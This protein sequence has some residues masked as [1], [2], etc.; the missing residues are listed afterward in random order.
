MEAAHDLLQETRGAFWATVAVVVGL[1]AYP[2]S[3]GLATVAGQNGGMSGLIDKLL[4]IALTPLGLEVFGLTIL[5]GSVVLATFT[6]MQCLGLAPV[7]QAERNP[8]TWLLGLLASI[9]LGIVGLC[10]SVLFWPRP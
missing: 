5:G 10:L 3:W 8:W 4:E 6:V 1:M 9:A 2:L 7:G